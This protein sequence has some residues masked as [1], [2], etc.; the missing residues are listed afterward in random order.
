M[1]SVTNIFKVLTDI[2]EDIVQRRI[3]NQLIMV[4]YCKSN[5]AQCSQT[6]GGPVGVHEN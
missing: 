1:E 6:K 3:R 2:T 4:T 5:T